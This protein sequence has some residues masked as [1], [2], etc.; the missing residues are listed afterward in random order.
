MRARGTIVNI[1][2]WEKSCTITPNDFLFGEKKYMG[3]VTYVNGDFQAVIDAISAGKITPYKM[4]TK[5]IRLDEVEE[6]GFKTLINDKDN[7]VKVLVE[8]GGG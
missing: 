7:Q 1:A 3:I 2:V 5:R 4:I 6:E 8:V